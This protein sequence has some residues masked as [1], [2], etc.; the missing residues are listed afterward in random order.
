MYVLTTGT[1][2]SAMLSA[3]KKVQLASVAPLP[4]FMILMFQQ[5]LVTILGN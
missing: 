3:L 2:E 4:W 5:F 1:S